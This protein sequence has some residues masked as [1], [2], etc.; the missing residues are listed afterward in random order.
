MKRT[1]I[2]NLASSIEDELI[3]MFDY[4]TRRS[5]VRLE[6]GHYS[7]EVFYDSLS[8]DLDVDILGNLSNMELFNL[9]QSIKDSI[10]TEKV[11]NEVHLE[12][13]VME[14]EEECEWDMKWTTVRCID[15]NKIIIT[16]ADGCPFYYGRDLKKFL[17]SEMEVK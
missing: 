6:S 1:E 8:G 14:R 4:D 17:K 16:G 13:S 5:V 2:Q 3:R 7:V 9:S 12:E 11:M 10:S 15:D